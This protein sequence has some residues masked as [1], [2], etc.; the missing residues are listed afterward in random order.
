M[1]TEWDDI[2]LPALKQIH[3]WEGDESVPSSTTRTMW[4]KRSASTTSTG[5][6]ASWNR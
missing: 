6:A 1:T 2:A 4:R 3:A 5:W